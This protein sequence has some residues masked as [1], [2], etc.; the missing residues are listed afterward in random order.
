MIEEQKDVTLDEMVKRL[1]DEVGVR[2]RCSTMSVWLYR[3]GWAFKKDRTRAGARAS[4]P[5]GSTPS[6]A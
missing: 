4:R 3:R 6:L 1:V 2:I 5:P